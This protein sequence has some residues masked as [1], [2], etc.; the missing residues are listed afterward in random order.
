MENSTKVLWGIKGGGFVEKRE[1]G[2]ERNDIDKGACEKFS[3]YMKRKHGYQTVR[4]GGG[5]GMHQ[6]VRDYCERANK[7]GKVV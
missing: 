4:G 3:G 2:E 5:G 6:M 1:E 7:L